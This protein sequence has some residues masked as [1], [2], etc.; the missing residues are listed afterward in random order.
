[1][2]PLF[3]A[4]D[5]CKNYG[6]I[7]ALRLPSFAMSKG[8][9]VVLAGRNGS[10]KSTLLR[11]LAFLEK[12]TSGTLRYYGNAS[13]PRKE[14][15]LLLQDAYLLKETVLHNV[16]LGLR[17]RGETHDLPQRF[18]NAMRAVGFDDPQAM[19]TRPQYKLSGGE[20]QRVALA[21]RIIL[22]PAVLLLDEPTAHVDADSEKTIL[23]SVASILEAGTSVVCATHDAGLFTAF[24]ARTVWLESAG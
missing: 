4:H 19:A 6:S 22:N 2:N 10:G 11:L 21:A 1:M 13:E 9:L 23:S 3:E 5:L 15:T 7:K 17:L 8:E 24:S 18:A 12:P 20:K 14:I 16:T